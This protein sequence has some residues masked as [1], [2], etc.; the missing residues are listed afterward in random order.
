MVSSAALLFRG[1]DDIRGEIIVKNTF[2]PVTEN[3]YVSKINF[4]EDI[5]KTFS[6]APDIIVADCTL[7]DGEQQPGI[8]FTKQ[9]KVAIAQKLSKLGIQEIEVGM[10]SSS[11][12]DAVAAKD[13]VALGL[14][15]TRITALARAL[16]DD[17]DLV[18]NLGVWG[19]SISLPIGDLQREHK[20]KWTEQK[21]LDTCL[22]IT[23]Y[24]KKKGLNVNLSPYD[25]TRVDLDFLDIVLDTVKK[26]GFVDR[27]RLV[28]T[29]GAANPAAIKYLVKRMKQVSGNLPLEI[30]VHDDFGMAVANTIAALEAG[31]DVI[32]STINGIGERSGNAATEEIVMAL[33]ILYGIDIGVNIGL[34]KETSEFIEKLSGVKLQAH[35]AVVGQNCFSYET[36][37]TVAGILHMPFTAQPYSPE[38]VGQK[39]SIVLGKKSGKTSIEYKLK[40][41][42]YTLTEEAIEKVLNKVKEYSVE[43]KKPVSDKEF[44]DILKENN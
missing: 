17:I 37:L 34:L 41:L 31:A 29:V 7:R 32:S 23:E 15:N 6:F 24:A 11:Q 12:E 20:L 14:E 1:V 43:H 39:T 27:V 28:D 25:T 42:G 36:G 9:D 5:Q 18:A 16:K 2:T 35:K 30:H 21:Y 40:E 38:I 19:V 3:W 8:V 33:K 4:L 22:S 10:P 26:S 44:I 13:I